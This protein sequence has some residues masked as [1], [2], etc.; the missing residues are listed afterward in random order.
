MIKSVIFGSVIFVAASAHAATSVSV[1]SLYSNLG[2]GGSEVVSITAAEGTLPGVRNAGT[3]L[4]TATA[5]ASNGVLK[6]SGSSSATSNPVT[7]IAFLGAG[8]NSSASWQ[9]LQTYTV[10]SAPVGASLQV[11]SRILILGNLATNF[12]GAGV[13]AVNSQYFASARWNFSASFNRL[14]QFTASGTEQYFQDSGR[15]ITQLVNGQPVNALGSFLVNFT[16]VNGSPLS[17]SFAIAASSTARSYSQQNI[18][19]AAS[20]YSFG[21]SIYWDGIESVSYNGISSPYTVQSLSGADYTQSF[22]PAAVPEPASYVLMLG[23]M[24]GIYFI[25]A[26]RQ[27]NGA[28]RST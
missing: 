28:S 3:E 4:A 22:A 27:P 15:N 13:G 17:T 18:L 26:R 25:Q 10:A 8:A 5:I 1:S 7:W 20:S 23:G 12:T 19:T 2:K 9:D 6:V 21:N 24:L 16:T 11:V 14:S